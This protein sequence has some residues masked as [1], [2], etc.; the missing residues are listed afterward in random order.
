MEFEDIWLTA[1]D[2]VALHAWLM[3]PRHWG[4][5][6]RRER[7]IVIFFQENAGEWLEN[8]LSCRWDSW[9]GDWPSRSGCLRGC[10]Q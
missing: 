9:V 7:P 6:P 4:S 3:W 8:G 5:K 2:G 10:R 1:A